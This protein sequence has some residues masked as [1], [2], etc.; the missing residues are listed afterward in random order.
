MK[1]YHSMI[2]LPSGII[3]LSVFVRF[4]ASPGSKDRE[5]LIAL[6]AFD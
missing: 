1:S 3:R 2:R 4:S 5:S 6:P